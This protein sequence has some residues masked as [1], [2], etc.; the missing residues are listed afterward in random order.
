[1][2]YNVVETIE[3]RRVFRRVCLPLDQ[4]LAWCRCYQRCTRIWARLFHISVTEPFPSYHIEVYH[5]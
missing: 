2:T 4:A 1:M 3:D 5:P